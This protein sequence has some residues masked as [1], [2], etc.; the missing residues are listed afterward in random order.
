MIQSA[1]TKGHRI[2]F[3]QAQPQA[4]TVRDRPRLAHADLTASI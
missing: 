4:I 3:F 2:D 1:V